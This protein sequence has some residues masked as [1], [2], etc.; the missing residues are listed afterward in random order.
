MSGLL[1]EPVLLRA[2]I[3]TSCDAASSRY[4]QDMIQCLEPTHYEYTK[5]LPFKN[6]YPNT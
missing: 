3:T 5:C 6:A 4:W 2:S 1:S